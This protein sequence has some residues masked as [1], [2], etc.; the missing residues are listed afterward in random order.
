MDNDVAKGLSPV[1]PELS[2]L[3]PDLRGTDITSLLTDYARMAKIV[4]VVEA[5]RF[6][7][8]NFAS[9]QNLG[10]RENLLRHACCSVAMDGDVL[11]FGVM[12]GQTLAILCDEFKELTVHGF[13][14]FKGLPEDWTH[15]SPTGTYS[16][17]GKLPT[18]LPSNSKLHVGLFEDTVPKYLAG[19]DAPVALLH[20][21]SDLYSSART[22]LFGLASRMRAGS[23]IVFDEFLNYP[24]W[25]QH[26]YR[27][28]MEFVDAFDVKF[29]YFS[30]ASSYLSVAVR[31]DSAPKVS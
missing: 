16:T 12:E 25:R 21:D 20:I 28:F 10:G 17:Q 24:G 13:D 6:L 31:L 14:S 15:D 1:L 4:S 11:E 2:G 26:E 27:A 29:R 19:T 30:F 7:E 8:E 3:L 18:R 5:A 9:A 22:A 23:I